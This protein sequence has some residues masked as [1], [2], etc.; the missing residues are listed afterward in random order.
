LEINEIVKRIEGIKKSIE[1][2][3]ENGT[4]DFDR[5][6][7]DLEIIKS[8]LQTSGIHVDL[9]P[10]QKRMLKTRDSIEH[11]KIINMGDYR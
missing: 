9:N 4:I 8:E 10:I 5:I 3:F 6:T 2:A 11:S 7:S 1:D